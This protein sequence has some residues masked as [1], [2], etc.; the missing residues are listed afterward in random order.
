MQC[1][2]GRLWPSLALALALVL[3]ACG[4]H[5]RGVQEV[6]PQLQQLR[7]VSETKG[8]A[9]EQKLAR[10]LV[11]AGVVLVESAGG[12]SL[13]T[14]AERLET[15]NVALDR[16]ARSAEQE[17]RV[18]VEFEL[19]NGAGDIVLGPH[20]LSTSRIYSYDPNSVIAKQDEES[21]ILTE[22]RNNLVGQLFR[23]LRHADGAILK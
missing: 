11:A 20:E 19:R 22:L 10:A 18:T 14:G 1:I 12:F 9:F 8:G 13:H 5:P 6:P 7:L 2:F 23:Q 21:L 15:R 4:W 3:G 17:M 16:E